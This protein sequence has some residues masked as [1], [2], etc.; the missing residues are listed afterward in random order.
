MLHA[1]RKHNSFAVLAVLLAGSWIIAGAAWGYS[2]GRI[3]PSAKVEAYNGD[4]VIQQYTR[5][6]PFPEG[7][8]LKT[9][10]R[11]GVRMDNFYLVAE[12]QTVFGI[13]HQNNERVLRIEQGMVYLAL[14]SLPAKLVFKTP[15]GAFPVQQ[16]LVQA[17]A[18][19]GA[20][21]AY[22]DVQRDRTEIGV[23]EGGRMVVTTPE[24]DRRITPGRQ[25]TIAQA[26]IFDEEGEGAG[27]AGEETQ[28]AEEP[29]E[30]AEQ[31][32]QKPETTAQKPRT[33][34]YVGV[35]LAAVAVIGGALAL[36]GGGGSGG[37]SGGGNGGDDPSVSPID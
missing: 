8:M 19:Q 3:I 9:Q 6:A 17:A 23:L 32:E 11:C 36:G 7:L 22:V 31:T 15:A 37:S 24:G 4:R 1:I 35:G 25:V 34:V 30:K 28:E 2:I 29:V 20:M 14:S 12:D 16:I 18:G 27:T 21:K 33:G 13:R 10:G 26:L 5:E